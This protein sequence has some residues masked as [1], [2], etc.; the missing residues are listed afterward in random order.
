MESA[1]YSGEIQIKPFWVPLFVTLLLFSCSP[2]SSKNSEFSF[3]QTESSKALLA[4]TERALGL[5]Q[6]NLVIPVYK[7]WKV[8]DQKEYREASYAELASN[9]EFVTF[10]VNSTKPYSSDPI[11][12]STMHSTMLENV[13]KW[14]KDVKIELLEEHK[15]RHGKQALYSKAFW[16]DQELAFISAD[17]GDS[18]RIVQILACFKKGRGEKVWKVMEDA[19]INKPIGWE[20]A[21][22]LR[23]LNNFNMVH[24]LTSPVS[25]P[26]GTNRAYC[27]LIDAK[28]L[29]APPSFRDRR[30]NHEAT[31]S[32]LVF[33]TNL[34]FYYP[35]SF[36]K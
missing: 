16:N 1:R 15:T 28:R 11:T 9:D 32:Q 25:G 2:G 36:K 24:N 34:R 35:E 13:K 20:M 10:Y 22:R 27:L 4:K 6:K 30:T 19:F 3:G 29:T 12:L 21:Y 33:D 18:F 14:L 17:P 5:G 8:L 7:G 31:L 23:T 26:I